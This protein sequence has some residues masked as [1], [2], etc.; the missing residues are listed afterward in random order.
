MGPMGQA[1]DG[2]GG[3]ATRAATF[4]RITRRAVAAA[5]VAM[6][7]AAEGSTTRTRTGTSK[8][9]AAEV[10]EW[11]VATGATTREVCIGRVR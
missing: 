9:V 6:V 8:V 1:E 3:E 10:A 11:A 7:A 5:E 2:A 4:S